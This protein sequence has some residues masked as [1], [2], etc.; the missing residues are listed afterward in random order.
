MFNKDHGGGAGT[1]AGSPPVQ[2]MMPP[3]AGTAPRSSTGSDWSRH[4]ATLPD[5]WRTLGSVLTVAGLLLLL[6][7]P[8]AEAQIL[9]L[10][11]NQR[12]VNTPGLRCWGSRVGMA[13]PVV[14]FEQPL[15]AARPLGVTHSMVAATG[16]PVGG[17]LPVITS[18]GVRGFVVERDVVQDRWMTM[19]C[20][21]RRNASNGHLTFTYGYAA[22]P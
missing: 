22:V 11:T 2:A 6:G 8:A 15:P 18:V 14:V 1:A 20:V 3:S 10:T 13:A 7:I 16:R 4:D 12:T 17:F 9:R 19:P 5:P 21:V